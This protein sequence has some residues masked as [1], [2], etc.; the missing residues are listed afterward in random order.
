MTEADDKLLK[1]FFTE[2]KHEIADNGF[3]HRVMQHLPDRSIRISG[4]FASICGALCVILFF[5][6]GGLRIFADILREVY[7]S[8]V[9]F[10]ATTTID[11]KTVLIVAVVL[12]IIGFNRVFSLD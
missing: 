5:A 10:F 3:T 2:Q 11:L 6:L 12:L 8:A 1:Q 4:L 9:Q 7:I